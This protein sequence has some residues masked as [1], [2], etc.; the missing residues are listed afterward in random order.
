MC[1]KNT[2]MNIINIFWSFN[3]L[4]TSQNIALFCLNYDVN[5][6]GIDYFAR[7]KND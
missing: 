7:S 1:E 5:C 3:A 2:T 6:Y 4:F